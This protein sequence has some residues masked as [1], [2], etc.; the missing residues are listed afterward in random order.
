MVVDQ[1]SKLIKRVRFTYPAQIIYNKNNRRII[2][3]NPQWRKGSASPNPNGRPRKDRLDIKSNKELRTEELE[4]ILNKLKPGMGK[5]IKCANEIIESKESS[6]AGKLRASALVI[7][8]YKELI[9]ELY[10]EK[11]DE[12]DAKELNS[13]EDKAP[14]FSLT[15]LNNENNE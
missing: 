12:D 8:T 7:Q 2:I 9:K 15:V 11:Y 6:E 3:A 10:S 4:G 13:E 1:P 14:V 5:A